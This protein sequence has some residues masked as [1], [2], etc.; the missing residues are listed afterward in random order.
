M[1]AQDLRS[2]SQ[3]VPGTAGAVLRAVLAVAAATALTALLLPHS[4]QAPF[5]IYYLAVLVAAIY[6][7]TSAGA[8]SVPQ[9]DCTRHG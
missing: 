2:R 1:T 3:P 9:P 4:K 6:G 8:L 7:G 5:T